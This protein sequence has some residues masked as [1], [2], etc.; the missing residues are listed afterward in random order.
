V[1]IEWEEQKRFPLPL[2][3]ALSKQFS[4]HGLQFFKRN[5]T[6]VHVSVARP[7]FLDLEATPVSEN[8]KRIVEFINANPRCTR[9]KLME[10]LAPAPAIAAPAE[11]PAAEASA[12]AAEGETAAK[13]APPKAEEPTPEQTAL[14]ADLHWLIHQGHVL[15]FADGRLETA[16]KPLPRPAR[17]EKKAEETKP[18]EEAKPAEEVAGEQPAAT[19]EKPAETPPVEPVQGE[20]VLSEVPP[21]EEASSPS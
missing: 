11:V 20:I 9:R 8:I 2:A 1:R 3:M 7:Q 14:I 17:P 13:P 16:K 6:A 15:E 5:K 10:T 21:V 4:S 19:E 12:P 18:V